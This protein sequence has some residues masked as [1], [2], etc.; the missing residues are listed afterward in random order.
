M[1]L[2]ISVSFEIYD[3]LRLVRLEGLRSL[4]VTFIVVVEMKNFLI[5]HSTISVLT[6]SVNVE[7]GVRSGQRYSF[8]QCL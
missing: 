7:S 5:L 6:D 2:I 8:L 4:F 1:V 3:C